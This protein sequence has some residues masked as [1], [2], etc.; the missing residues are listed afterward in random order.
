[1]KAVLATS[2]AANPCRL[3]YRLIPSGPLSAR[4]STLYRR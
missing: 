2:S 4:T 3:I 1:M